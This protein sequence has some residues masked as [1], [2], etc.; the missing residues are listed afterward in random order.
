[1]KTE[2]SPKKLN[3]IEFIRFVFAVIIVYFHILHTNLIS[4][5]NGGTAFLN[6]IAQ[7]CAN[8]EYAVE[9][10]FIIAGYFLFCSYRKNPHL[11]V[12]QF[13]FKKFTRLWPVLVV[14]IA[15]G[16]LFFNADVFSSLFNLLF[17]QCIGVSLDYQ[18]ISWYVSPFFWAMIFYYVLLRCVKNRKTAHILIGVITYFSYVVVIN[19]GFERNTVYGIFSLGLLRALGGIGA[20]YLIGLCLNSIQNLPAVQ[21]FC[22]TKSQ[23]FIISA[24]MSVV[25]AGCAALLLFHFFNQ[26]RAYDNQFFVVI[27]FSCLLV[28]MISGKGIFSR[29]FNNR[30]FGFFGRYS[31]SI[32][33]MQ[34]V[35]FWILKA[36]FWKNTDFAAQ[37][38]LWCV[39][40]SAAFAVVLGIVT[41]Y[42]VEKPGAALLNKAGKKLFS[43][44]S[45]KILP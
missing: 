32:Y 30:F 25:E 13:A 40:I 11:S 38:G 8:A 2:R 1:M 29:L 3:N 20:G 36:T 39:A 19:N 6:E 31:Y 37:H 23:N 43:R 10:F 5:L 24:T 35:A 16:V 14:S 12:K 34:Q 15:I 4:A 7:Q 22:G 33:M 17:L 21:N 9:C 26:D 41:Y 18:G 27:V 45:G 28:C 42:L 44:D